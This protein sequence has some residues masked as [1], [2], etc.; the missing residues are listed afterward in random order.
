MATPPV[1]RYMEIAAQL[2]H[3]IRSGTLSPGDP[4]PS[5]AQLCEQFNA[6]R[7]TV[8]QAV[9]I[10]RQEGMVSSGQ[11]RRT[12]VI[13]TLPTQSFDHLFSFTQWCQASGVTPGQQTQWVTRTKA[14]PS[15]AASLELADAAPVVSV[16]RLRLMDGTPAMVE[17]LNY[18]LEFGQHV[19]SFDPDSGSIYQ[20]LVDCG[21]PIDRATRTIDALPADPTDAELLRVPTGTALLRVRRRAFTPDGAVIESSDDRY[22]FDKASITTTVSRHAPSPVAMVCPPQAG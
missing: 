10:L 7:G 2:R 13:D 12:R 3:D 22:L 18:P 4:L 15:L 6:A 20:R 9:G 14:D 16:L 21:V 1:Q 5:E 11:G 19:L 8:R 17:R